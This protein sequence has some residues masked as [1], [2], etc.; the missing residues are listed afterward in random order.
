MELTN[1][2]VRLRPP[3]ES[4]APAVVAAVQSSLA[5]LSPWLPWAT[6]AYDEGSALQWICGELDPSEHGF[7]ILGHDQALVGICGLNQVNELHN[8]ANLGYWLRTDCTGHGWAAK[9]TRILSKYGINEVGLHRLEIL[10]SVENEPSRLVA[11]RAGAE[12]EGVQRGALQLHGR[13]HDAHCFS[14]VAGDLR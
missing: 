11:E 3:H 7:L 2:E 13:Y 6:D 12:Y 9:A 1:G 8:C 14:I 10:M 5:E 4:D